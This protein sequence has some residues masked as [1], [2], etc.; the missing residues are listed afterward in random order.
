MLWPKTCLYFLLFV[1]RLQCFCSNLM[2]NKQFFLIRTTDS[3]WFFKRF[4]LVL[5]DFECYL[6]LRFHRK[7]KIYY[8][9]SKNIKFTKR[10]MC[11]RDSLTHNYWFSDMFASFWER[12]IANL[13][14]SVYHSFSLGHH[15]SCKRQSLWSLM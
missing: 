6:N 5:L 2:L 10:E 15:Y 3:L 1:K 13:I 4:V 11:I 12:F 8:Y 14:S 9:N 7:R